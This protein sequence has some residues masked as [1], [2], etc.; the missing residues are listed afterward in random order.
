MFVKIPSVHNQ[1]TFCVS[2]CVYCTVDTKV[3][4]QQLYVQETEDV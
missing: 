3:T 2:S 1:L 4:P